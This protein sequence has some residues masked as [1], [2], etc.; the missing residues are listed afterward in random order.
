MKKTTV[1]RVDGAAVDL[2]AAV[3]AEL[4]VLPRGSAE[5]FSRPVEI[6]DAERGRVRYEVFASDAGAMF[7]IDVKLDDGTR[8]FVR[9]CT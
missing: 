5:A 7:Q 1:I 4:H 6:V 8:I 3:W 9:N 2:S